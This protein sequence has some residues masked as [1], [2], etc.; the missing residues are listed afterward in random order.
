MS[1]GS[2]KTGGKIVRILIAKEIIFTDVRG[3]HKN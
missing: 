2:T 3:Q 1:E